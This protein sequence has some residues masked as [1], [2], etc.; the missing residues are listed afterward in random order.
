MAR[1]ALH[2]A[3]PRLGD[4]AANLGAV[5]NAVAAKEAELVVFP[6]MFAS[7]YAIGDDVQ[8]LALTDDDERWAPLAKA[9]KKAKAHAIVGGPRKLRAGVTANSAFL[10]GPDG[11]EAAYDKR[12]LATFTTFQEGLFFRPGR[13]SPVWDTPVGKV[14]IGICYDLFFPEFSRAQTLAGADILLNISASPSTSQRFFEALLAARAIENACFVGYSNVAGPQD[15]LVF[16]G[17][18]QAHSP[19]GTLMGRTPGMEPGRIVV[20]MDLDDLAPAREFRP[21]LRDGRLEDLP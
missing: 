8:R 3:T 19:R 10:V 9:C 15:A 18:A 6:E 1:I 2:A 14:G 17:G 13:G 11:V 4:V 20:D 21:T 5:A 7:G 12:A 16:W